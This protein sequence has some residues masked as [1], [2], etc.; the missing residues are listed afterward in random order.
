MID[1]IKQY[2]FL[3]DTKAKQ[4]FPLLIVLFLGSSM[5]D[6]VGIGM[7]SYFLLVIENLNHGNHLFKFIP[8]FLGS[9]IS[10][11]PKK[12]IFLIGIMIVCIFIFKAIIGCWIQRKIS[13]FG[14]ELALRLK[15]KLMKAY[16][17][18]PY[19]FH[20]K[21]N[22]AYLINRIQNQLNDYISGVLIPSLILLSNLAIGIGVISLLFY[23][24]PI[25]TLILSLLFLSILIFNGF[26]IK[27][28][29]EKLGKISTNAH[30]EIIKSINH[31]LGGL[32]EIRV[33]GKETY[34][35]NQLRN[36]SFPLIEAMTVHSTYQTI[37]RYA[38]ESFMVLFVVALC[39]ISINLGFESAGIVPVLGV[40]V[41]ASARLMPTVNQLVMGLN[42]I[43]WSSYSIKI[44]TDELRQLDNY[45][46]INDVDNAPIKNENFSKISLIDVSFRYPNAKGD[47]LRRINMNILKG[48]S[49]GLIGSSGAGKSTLINII[50]G[51]LSPDSGKILIDDH[52]ISD[53]RGW[54]NNFACIPQTIFLLDDTLKRNIALG[55]HDS[56]IDEDK[57]W[58]TIKMAQLVNVVEDLPNGIETLIGENGVRLSGGQ[59]QRV[60][61][62]RALYHERDIIIMDEATSALDNETEKEIINAIKDLKGQKTLIVIAHR[63]TTVEHCDLIFK[64]E[65]GSIIDSGS[66]EKVVKKNEIKIAS[67][68]V[69]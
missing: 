57:L 8:F 1:F 54:L 40:F 53:S 50:L 52:C 44:L 2:F 51:L 17:Y 48:Q 65:N 66:F 28:K 15:I 63:L 68:V 29:L 26:I 56:E 58:A 3:L 9:L 5:L 49:I 13:N 42:Q 35:L 47:A 60:A 64:M 7:V 38:I 11:D 33:L 25:S 20:L 16:Q 62:A 34:F 10:S 55:M 31:G 30:G 67:D 46:L 6:V 4:K 39:L 23:L 24:N 27:S 37:P 69:I 36:A 21:N 43:R 22:S 45:S 59:R 18:A 12:I 32:K 41:A 19:L 61:L 14:F